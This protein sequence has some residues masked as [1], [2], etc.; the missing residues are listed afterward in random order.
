M[1]ILDTDHFSVVT[2]SRHKFH[3]ALLARLEHSGDLLYEQVP[4]LRVE[5]W[6][7]DK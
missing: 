5:D 2:D 4:G 6:L 7:Y 3:S 1:I